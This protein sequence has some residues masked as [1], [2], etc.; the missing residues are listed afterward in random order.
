MTEFSPSRESVDAAIQSVASAELEGAPVGTTVMIN[1]CIGY[2]VM[3]FWW[4]LHVYGF[5]VAMRA[6]CKRVFKRNKKQKQ[7]KTDGKAWR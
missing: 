6:W 5:R 7:E 4:T 1:E 3:G 2:K